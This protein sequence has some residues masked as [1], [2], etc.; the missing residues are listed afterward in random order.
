MKAHERYFGGFRLRETSGSLAELPKS[1]ADVSIFV[2]NWETRSKDLLACGQ[3]TGEN[4]ILVRFS[5][6]PGDDAYLAH[7]ADLAKARFEHVEFAS[8]TS[9]LNFDALMS[10]SEDL[11]RKICKRGPLSCAVDYTSMPKAMVQTLFRQFMIEGLCPIVTWFYLP[12]LYDETPVRLEESHQGASQFFAIRG[13]EGSG[14]M[15][16]RRVGIVAL[17]ADKPLTDAFLR[18]HN[19][20]ETYFVCA[21]SDKSPELSK[22]MDAHKKWLMIEHGAADSDFIN[23]GALT[24]IEALNAFDK[25]VSSAPADQGCS[26]DLFCSGPKSHGIAASALITNHEHV[27]LVARQPTSY[28]RFDVKSLGDVSVTT[29]SD[30]TNPSM[31][32]ALTREYAK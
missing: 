17:G 5:D 23:C 25:I 12:G 6:W 18:A 7:L 28:A 11:A 27:R 8:L 32:R 10:D 24:V 22:K 31:G 20:D 4:C 3:L 30:F 15:S 19:Y 14:G 29:I 9:P 2:V 26:V 21:T 13:A 16:T 1:R